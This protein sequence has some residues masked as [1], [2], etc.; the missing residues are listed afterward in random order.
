MH[1]FWRVRSGGFGRK[2]KG[3]LSAG[4]GIGGLCTG[5]GT[6]TVCVDGVREG[7][8]RSHPLFGCRCR[9]LVG[10]CWKWG[11]PEVDHLELL[12][13]MTKDHL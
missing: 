5:K 10:L 12:A 4:R 9:I 2:C 8:G 13:D 1:L 6:G 3:L 11:S 7:V